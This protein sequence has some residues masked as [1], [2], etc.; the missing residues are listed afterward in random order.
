M[1]ET[2]EATIVHDFLAGYQ[3]ILISDFYPGYDAV[4]CRQQKCLVHLIRDLNE[5]LWKSPY[6]REF[7]AFIL[8]VKNLLVSILEAVQKYGL[9]QRHLQKF[10][11]QIDQ[12]YERVITDRIY[13][14]DLVIKYQSR[15]KRYRQSLFTFIAHDGIPWN[16]NMAERAIKRL[17]TA[18]MML[19]AR[20]TQAPFIFIDALST[21]AGS[22]PSTSSAGNARKKSTA[23]MSSRLW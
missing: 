11:K 9:K 6:D 17:F 22:G 2:R 3:G 13:H 21:E 15:F 18:C 20:I 14:S 4:Q 1:T 8:E 5:D 16:N 23:A 7:E 12:F 10:S 19:C